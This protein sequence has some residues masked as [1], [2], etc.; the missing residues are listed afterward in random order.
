MCNENHVGVEWRQ[1]RPLRGGANAGQHTPTH[2]LTTCLN[3]EVHG[4]IVRTSSKLLETST[5]PKQARGCIGKYVVHNST[6]KQWRT[7]GKEG[8]AKLAS[9]HATRVTPYPLTG[10][11]RPPGRPNRGDLRRDY[12]REQVGLLAFIPSRAPVVPPPASTGS[13]FWSGR[14]Q[15]VHEL[16]GLLVD[17]SADLG[18][19]VSQ[20]PAIVENED[21]CA[22][23]RVRTREPWYTF[24]P[25]GMRMRLE[26]RDGTSVPWHTFNTT[27]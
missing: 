26:E 25:M 16:T 22:H 11:P 20:L 19:V 13:G 5:N 3:G 18:T 6:G 14:H 23:T 10:R 9:T 15:R 21:T 24:V 4:G 1:G 2:P 17:P 7:K 8:G 27:L 12:T